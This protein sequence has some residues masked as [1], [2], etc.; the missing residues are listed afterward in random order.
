MLFENLG[1]TA[2]PVLVHTDWKGQIQEWLPSPGAFNHAIVK[3]EHRSKI[4]WIDPTRAGQ[5]G[6][7]DNLSSVDYEIGLVIGVQKENLQVIEKAP[8]RNN[9]IIKTTFDLS[10]GTPHAIMLVE[11]RYSREDANWFRRH[12]RSIKLPQISQN[13]LDFFTKHYNDVK[14]LSDVTVHE[15]FEENIFIVNESYTIDDLGKYEEENRLHIFEVYPVNLF[16]Y[17]NLK[18]DLK[19]ETPLSIPYPFDITD[20]IHFQ[21]PTKIDVN[22][23][24]LDLQNEYMEYKSEWIKV[25]EL[26]FIVKFQF[27]SKKDHINIQDLPLVKRML[28]KIDKDIGVS[29]SLDLDQNKENKP[30]PQK[31]RWWRNLSPSEPHRKWLYF[32]AIWLILR[33]I[34]SFMSK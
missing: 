31:Q 24:G 22:G 10:E 20:E 8:P 25:D 19:R 33:S 32:S 9:I 2:F 34:W 12:L 26:H 23:A 15:N 13:Y 29:L 6:K 16:P 14:R 21:L 5:G 30:S 18:I 1:F 17:I 3:L 11:T 4:Y 28:E 7:L 27:K